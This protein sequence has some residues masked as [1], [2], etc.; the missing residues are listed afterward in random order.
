MDRGASRKR[1]RSGTPDGGAADR[2]TPE[3][4]VLPSERSNCLEWDV[5][6]VCGFLRMH[7]WEKFEELFRDEKLSGATL[8]YLTKD[9]LENLGVSTLGDRIN[10]I[11]CISALWQ[12]PIDAK[13]FN[14][15]IHG[16][17]EMHPL[18]V[19]IIDTPQFQRLRFIKQLGATYFVYP[20]ASH[21]RFEHSIGVAHLAGELVKALSGRQPELRI[22]HRDILCVQIAGLCHD[23]GHGPFSHLFDGKF[24]PRM[25]SGLKWKHEN[26][27]I[28]MFDH[29]ISSNKLEKVLQ[30]YGLDLSEDLVFIKEMIHGV[31]ANCKGSVW[32]YKGRS[33][34]KSFLYEIVANK[35]TGI[36]VDKW[37]Y[38]A[39]DCHHLG[40]R[41]NFDFQRFL[42]F[43]RVY[44]VKKKKVI[45]TR[46]KEAGDLYNMFHTRNTLHRR[47]YQ[48]RVVNSIESMITEAMVLA[49]PHI[50]ISGSDGKQYRMST[51][52]GDMEAYTKLTDSIF[53][54]ILNSADAE[55]QEA[56]EVL[57]NVVCRKLYKWIGQTQPA[58]DTV[59]K[60]EEFD[61][62]ADQLVAAAPSAPVEVTLRAED[63]IVN[64]VQMDYGMKGKNPINKVRFYCKNSPNKTVKISKKQVSQ[65]L[66]ERFTEQLIQVYCKRTNEEIV[67]AA[68]KHFIKWC[69]DRDFAKPRD[70]DIIAPELTPLKADWNKSDSDSDDSQ[71]AND[72]HLP[73]QMKIDKAKAQLFK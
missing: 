9:D 27:S 38:F 13:V 56:R 26:A 72:V 35:R 29:L 4:G 19:R 28:E 59:I 46:D 41:N 17:I 62:L 71:S 52:I 12:S 33:Q 69:M 63:L 36:D 61:K 57:S 5:E 20:G 16:H 31:G 23:L 64:V 2:R 39:R 54:Q 3:R 24:I 8:P 67:Q 34:E 1:R 68:R 37:D 18:L 7:G 14:D 42:K 40:I 60:Q 47:A 58:A 70:G 21:N 50:L 45:C 43:A 6:D 11:N 32:P 30:S 51:A 66:P 48:H 49:D 73:Q 15:P 65:L 10:L 44:E 22:N 25:R 53:E 55:L